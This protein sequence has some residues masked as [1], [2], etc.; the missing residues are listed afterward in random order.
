MKALNIKKWAGAVACA[1][2][3]SAT[4]ALAIPTVLDTTS[5]TYVG[6]VN[7][8]A[9]SNPA[10][11]V[12]YINELIELTINTSTTFESQTLVRSGNVLTL[13]QA[14]VTGGIKDDSTPSNVIDI[15]GWTYLYA[16]YGSGNE[17]IGAYVWLVS[18]LTG[19]VEVPSAKLSHWSLY[20]PGRTTVPDGG[21]A[22]LLLGGAVT[23]LGFLRRKISA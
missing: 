8:S 22:L 18:G 5:S 14:D 21:S 11:E 16:K 3:I 1:T 12:D 23:A 10:N 19:E 4:S 13:P 20:N 9:P 17:I 6:S 7:P 2:L 15:S